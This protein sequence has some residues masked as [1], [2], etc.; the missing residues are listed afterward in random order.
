[1]P[2]GW[3]MPLMTAVTFLPTRSPIS[4]ITCASCSALS[5]SRINAPLPHFTSSTIPS[6]PAAI[7]LDIMLAAISGILST[8]PVT[9]RRAYSFLS[10]GVRLPVWLI[11]TMRLSF[12]N[13]IASSSVTS[14]R[15][16]GI[17]S[18]L[19]IVPPEK[20]SPR[21]LIFTTG[22]STDAT[23]G[24]STSVV[25]SPTPPVLCLSALKPAT[26]ERSNILPER[27]ISIV[28]L[29]VSSASIPLKNTA[30]R[31]AAT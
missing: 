28:R 3:S 25:V 9:S 26:P 29:A 10:A 24:A 6:A 14:T 16:P 15:K 30:I 4:A 17:D 19:S 23:S 22:T 2:R 27:A 31:N 21:P 18:S 5:K 1:M 13:R 11:S 8:V 12:A 7:F 20:P